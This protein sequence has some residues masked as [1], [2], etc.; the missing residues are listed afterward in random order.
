[1]PVAYDR[2]QENSTTTGT[3]TYTL[4][5]AVASY[6]TFA[7]AC[8]TG[9]VVPYVAVDTATGDWEIGLGTYSAG[10]LARTTIRRSTNANAA[11]SW[12]SGTRQVFIDAT[13]ADALASLI[14]SA[15]GAGTAGQV[16]TSGGSG[17]NPVYAD[18]AFGAPIAGRY[19]SN[20]AASVNNSNTFATGTL[21]Y[22][23]FAVWRGFTISDIGIALQS[24]LN[25][26]AGSK[27]RFGIYNSATTGPGS[28]LLDA[29]E[30]AN[31][32]F[33][34]LPSWNGIAISG[35]YTFPRPGF[36]WLAATFNQ[37]AYSAGGGIYGLINTAGTNMSSNMI[38]SSLSSVFAV[39]NS[40]V[41]GCTESFTYGALPST[42][43]AT[44]TF[45]AITYP[46]VAV[47]AA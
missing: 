36:Y 15:I 11:V 41:H 12:A 31:L 1:M 38:G 46:Q 6:R 43:S 21:Y 3:G 37:S 34:T 8:S 19:Y 13:A 45:G 33:G 17:A 18:M 23:P 30:T 44:P 27:A 28:L 20:H 29:G 35:N 42:A 47:R 14:T 5:G 16:L 26:V 25:L 22:V 39:A 7:A 24:S 32:S 10:T 4:S 9:D 2:V 40:F